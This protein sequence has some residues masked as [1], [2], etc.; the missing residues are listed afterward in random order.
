MLKIFKRLLFLWFILLNSFLWA[1]GEDTRITISDAAS[2]YENSGTMSFTIQLSEEPDWGDSVTVYYQTHDGTAKAGEDYTETNGSVTFYGKSIFPPHLGDSSKTITVDIIDDTKYESSENLYVQISNSKDG[3]EVT[4]DK[5]YGIIYSDDAKPLKAK[6]YN[7]WEK[8]KD[9]N[10]ILNFTVKLNQKAPQDITMH[11]TTKDNSAKAGDDYQSVNGTLKI[12]KNSKYGYISVPIIADTL[13]ENHTENF[14]VKIDSISSGT[15]IRD[16]ATGTIVDDD[17]IKVKISSN[18][19]NEGNSGDHNSMAFKIYLTKKY[20][21]D[22][23]LTINY[24]TKDGSSPSATQGSDYTKTTGSVTF[25]KGDRKFIVNVPIVGDNVIEPDE[26]LKM[27]ISGSSYIVRNHSESEILN[28]DGSYPSVDFSTGDFEVTEGN[29]STKMLHF[30]FELN[31]GAFEDSYFYYYTKDD[32]AKVE[33]NDYVKINKKKYTLNKGDKNI[34]IDVIINGDTKIEEDE[35]FY[36]KFTDEH[37][38]NITGHTAKGKILNDD[39]SHPRLY[40]THTQYSTSEG[41]SS[42]K[43][44][45]ITLQLDKPMPYKGSFRYRTA[46]NTSSSN[47]A[48]ANDDYQ[49]INYTTYYLD[50]GEQNITIP[51]K[52]NGD[53]DIEN[54][55]DFLFELEQ[56]TEQNITIDEGSKEVIILNDDGSYPTIDINSSVY[57]IAEGNSS[58]TIL[59][60]MFKLDAPALNGSSIKYYTADNTAQ[61]GSK[62]SEDR[63]YIRNTGELAIEENATTASIDIEILGDTLIEPDE[64]FNFYIH[65]PKNLTIGRSVTVINIIN[66]DVHSNDPFVCDEHMYIS[67]SKKRGSTQTGKMWLHRIDTTQNPFRFEVMD[68]DGEDNLYNAIAYNP[69]DNYIYGLYYRNL[70]KLT[71]SGKVIN[72]G[73]INGLPDSFETKQLYAGAINNGYYFITGRNTKQNYMFKV[74]LSDMSVEDIN[75]TQ[76]VAIQDFSFYNESNGTRFLY[77]IDKDGKLTKIDSIT[78]RVRFIGNDHT[79]YKFDSSFSDK[80]GRFFANDSNGNGFFEFNLATGEKSFIS[81]SQ[82]ATFNDGANCINAQLLFTDFG[83]APLRYAKTWHNIA[84]GIYLGDKVDHDVGDYDT[85]NADGDDLNGVDDDDGVTQIDG[86]D[87]NGTYFETNATHQLKVKLSKEA[88]LKIWIDTRIDGTFDNGADLV[89]NS[90]SK[91]SAGEHTISFTLP[92]NLKEN[93]KTYL[94]A[95]VSSYPS[96]NPTGFVQDGEV[97]DYLIYFGDGIHPLRGIFNIERTNSGLYPIN[98]SDRNAWFTQIV[99]RDFDYS[100][101]FYEEDMSAQKELDNVTVK[102]DL[103]DEDT[104][105][106]LYT[107][108]AYIKNTPPKSRIDN[109]LPH[110]LDTLPATKRA[111]FKISYGVNS[112]GSII[113]TPCTTNPKTCFDALPNTAFVYARDDFAIRPEYFHMIVYDNN[114]SIRVSTA[115]NNT[116][117]LKVAS[118]YD[119]NLSIT[120][121]SYNGNDATPSLNYSGTPTRVLEFL[122]KSNIN[123]VIKNDIN[124]TEN[125]ING[126]NITNL[127][128]VQES[129]KYR[130]HLIDNS[131]SS[132]DITKGD[133]DINSST[134]SANGNIKSGCNIVSTKDINLTFYPDHFAIN[135]NIQNLPNSSHNDFIYMSE[136]N[137]TFNS[138]AIAY[139]GDIVAQ[140]EDNMTTQ[141]F[142][143]GCMS[144]DVLLKLNATTLSDR[145]VDSSLKTSDGTTDVKFVRTIEFN[146]DGNITVDKDTSL[147]GLPIINI[148]SNKFI[149]E[150]NGSANIDIRYNI[151]KNLSKTINP[152]QI[153]F[154]SFDVNS[155]ASTSIS[156][157]QVLPMYIP[158]G[159]QDLGDTIRNFYFSQITPDKANY[160]TID[161]NIENSIRTPIQVEIFCGNGVSNTLCVD[162]NLT[163]HTNLTSSPRSELGWYISIDHNGSVDGNII[164]LVPNNI[165]PNVLSITPSTPIELNNGR[166]GTI[167]TRFTNPTDK[168][169]YRVDIFCS[170]Q[171]KH[172]SG[173]PKTDIGGDPMPLG[174]PDYIV[175]G[176]DNNSSTWTG[177]GKTGRILEI[178]SNRNSAHKMDW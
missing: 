173:V 165:N 13:P 94:R 57:S 138:V 22:T 14:Y 116:T 44:I 130:L 47:K 88:Y 118:G 16:T 66:D 177:V 71:K 100:L 125:F 168:Q 132:I 56:S 162:T 121:S 136:M 141:N 114:N 52:I 106:T 167:M 7:R 143:N 37:H 160:P 20:P 46:D 127:L 73:K 176:S 95:R 107:K 93:T 60:V 102:I 146:S 140:S 113:Q 48:T 12:T 3:Y 9:N 147:N 89:Y 174:V 119:Y 27:V 85:I 92:S 142:T 122:D 32:D 23:P 135:L 90:G 26:N 153:T 54:D 45:N 159:H 72:L 11:Y 61:D 33:D 175:S 104:N 134:V 144:Q 163:T 91:L 30:H 110:D 55:E 161:F 156:H 172:Y 31:K 28:D 164:G 137:S 6:I 105:A 155:S 101:V 98:S 51:V 81:S 43:D 133:C 76:S 36:L 169:I 8:E 129:G 109:T 59:K 74:K 171:L 2:V 21:L 58:K 75:L 42:Q 64:S 123:C 152:I 111:I 34:D 124:S 86:S 19:V 97:E 62:S 10:W 70:I 120:A 128:E 166:I 5:G 115:P 149:S 63:D 25:H 170:P 29:T 154:H 131:W 67:S 84:N 38:L 79:G 24:T 178:K 80:N 158:I 77:G 139:Q 1:D 83:D 18:D 78:G 53:T 148:T 157:K 41:N 68:D 145:G 108:Y 39:G 87:I 15:I 35:I 69:D 96:M 150:H 126:K 151:D 50:I 65:S 103:I 99:G 82:P 49:S 4:D 40:F 17:A 117:P 112:D